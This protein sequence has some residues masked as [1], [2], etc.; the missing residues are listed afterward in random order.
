M[1]GIRVLQI[2]SLKKAKIFANVVTLKFSHE[3]GHA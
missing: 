1:L 2:L 3:L